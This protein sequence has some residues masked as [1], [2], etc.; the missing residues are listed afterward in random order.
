MTEEIL[1]KRTREQL[2]LDLI[3]IVKMSHKKGYIFTHED[4]FA[5]GYAIGKV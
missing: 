2:L 5:L 3:E 1:E 4:A